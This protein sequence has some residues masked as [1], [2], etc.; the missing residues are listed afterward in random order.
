VCQLDEKEA[1]RNYKKVKS[2]TADFTV[3]TVVKKEG[4]TGKLP[5][6]PLIMNGGPVK[7]YPFFS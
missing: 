4:W 5:T 6:Q 2:C 3:E 1:K 7:V